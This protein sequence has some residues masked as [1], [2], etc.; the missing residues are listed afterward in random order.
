M[1]GQSNWIKGLWRQPLDGGQPQR[2]ESLPDE[3]IYPY[4][5]SHDGKMF[6]FTR[7]VEIRDVV[8]ISNSK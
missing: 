1:A 3:K 8:L 7:G 5:W 6:A 2:I 4:S